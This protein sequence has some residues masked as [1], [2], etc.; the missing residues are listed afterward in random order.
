MAISAVQISSTQFRD[1]FLPGS[2]NVDAS[3]PDVSNPFAALQL[4]NQI[5]ERQLSK[6]FMA[7]VND[8]NLV[9][10]LT[11]SSYQQQPTSIEYDKIGHHTTAALFRNTSIPKAGQP[12]W[13]DQLLPIQFKAKDPGV[14]PFSDIER[15]DEYGFLDF[16][17]KQLLDEISATAELLLAAQ[18]RVFLFMF[19]VI[20]R[21][22]RLL[23]WDRAGVIVTPPIDYV[24]QPSVLCDLLWRISHLNDAG[25]GLDPSATR[26]LPGDVD[27][28][29]M[30]LAAQKNPKDMSHME[31]EVSASEEEEPF[32]FDYVRSLFRLSI[33]N[34]WPRYKLEV[35]DGT[36]SR[37]YLVGKPTFR[38][39]GVTGRG[40]RGYVAFDCKTGR[41]VWLKDAWRASYM[42]SRREGDVLEKLNSAGIEHVPTLVCHGD[43]EDQVTI[44]ADWWER[45]C[46]IS[47]VSSSSSAGSSESSSS[48]LSVSASPRSRKRK[49][50]QA[51][52]G[53]RSLQNSAYSSS[54]TVGSD[55]PLP[56]H[57]HYRLAVEEVCLPLKNFE[58][59]R[60]LVFVVLHCLLAH[61][62]AATNPA[63]RLLHGDISG[64]NIL[65]YPRIKRTYDGDS[66]MMLWTGLLTDWELSKSVGDDEALCTASQGTYQF[67]SVNRLLQ[68]EPKAIKISDELESFFHVLVYYSVRSLH[69]NCPDVSFWID[70]YFNTYAAL[71]RMYP[72]GQ[73]SSTVE[74]TGRL[75]TGAGE[76]PLLFE[77]P[78]DSILATM[79]QCLRA[80]YKII[81]DEGRKLMSAAPARS[82]MRRTRSSS[83]IFDL[84]PLDK[85]DLKAILE[86]EEEEE[87]TIPKTNYLPAS[88]C[89]DA[90]TARD[91][92]LASKI[93]THDYFLNVLN[94]LVCHPDWRGGDRIPKSSQCCKSSPNVKADASKLA[95][96]SSRTDRETSNKRRRT[97]G[98]ERN[99]SLRARLRTSTR[100]AQSFP[101]RETCYKIS[102]CA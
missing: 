2:A 99:V 52:S 16:S 75:Q 78:M 5:K 102:P 43:V 94:S 69:S 47:T 60:Q 51:T 54:S 1:A 97:S 72:C 27:F 84:I 71:G 86:E 48:T 57:K 59:G 85:Y 38:A 77:S 49:R 32:V 55:Q 101:V 25:I 31:R 100:H 56:E 19:L 83:P 40:T 8:H 12:V 36:A 65:I 23:R 45:R 46:P 28:L 14:D 58:Y 79:L 26:V 89:S 50:M 66:P 73:K 21:R 68:V 39:P 24:K 22:F 17:R 53:E 92:D 63:T 82:H 13:A 88:S 15:N 87:Y 35:A 34:D 62:Q 6:R 80:H 91:R 10:G 96:A 42:I 93:T 20:G 33:S 90:P 11:C 64:G 67:M 37:G 29:R 30:D 98:P 95:S 76:G 41:F 70:E 74:S 7:I 81:Q 4:A 9:Q 61:H 3:R 18:Q 44:T